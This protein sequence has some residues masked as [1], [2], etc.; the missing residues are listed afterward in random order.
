MLVGAKPQ[1]QLVGGSDHAFC[2]D[3]ARMRHL[4]SSRTGV[5]GI[6]N[7]GYEHTESHTAVKRKGLLSDCKPSNDHRFIADFVS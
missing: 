3:H 2:G 6:Q 4:Y 5:F 1:V 7:A